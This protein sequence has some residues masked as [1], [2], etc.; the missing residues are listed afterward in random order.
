MHF[1]KDVKYMDGYKLVVTFENN[2]KKI[3]N[4]DGHL[5]KGVFKA[6]KDISYFKTVRI[7]HELDTVVWDN[8]ADISPDFLYAIGTNLSSERLTA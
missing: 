6:L 2:E 3:V 7:D 5:E 4:L 8:G 1:I